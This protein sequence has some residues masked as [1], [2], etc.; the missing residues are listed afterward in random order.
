MGRE[1]SNTS[2]VFD[3]DL[4]L[5]VYRRIEAGVNPELELLRFLT[6]RGFPSIASLEG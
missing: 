3:D 5:K 1:Q 2:L 6:D 4:V